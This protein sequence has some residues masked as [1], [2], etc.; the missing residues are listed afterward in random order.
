VLT[1]MGL[2]WLPSERPNKQLKE[3]DADIYTQPMERSCCPCGWIREKLEEAKEQ[4]DTVGRP[5]VSINLDLW[6][7]SNSGPPTRQQC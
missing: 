4:G 3:L 7:L 6:D 5:A 1:K 2:S